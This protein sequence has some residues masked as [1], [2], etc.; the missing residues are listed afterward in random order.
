VHVA[1]REPWMRREDRLGL[2]ERA[3]RM[4]SVARAVRRGRGDEE[5][6]DRVGRYAIGHV[7]ASEVS[8]FRNA[9]WVFRRW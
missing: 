9:C 3:G 8:G 7:A 1:V 6:G 5:R 4:R 2:F